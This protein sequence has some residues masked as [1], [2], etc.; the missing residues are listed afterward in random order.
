MVRTCRFAESAGPPITCA[1][2]D[3]ALRIASENHAI[4]EKI[5]RIVDVKCVRSRTL[6]HAAKKIGAGMRIAK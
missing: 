6:V 1:A 5:L 4:S 3:D 2:A